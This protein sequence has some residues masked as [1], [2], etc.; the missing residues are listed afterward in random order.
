MPFDQVAASSLA[1]V[2]GK[3][4]NLG[5]L[6]AAGFPVPPGFVVTTQAYELGKSVV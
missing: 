2:G 4:L 1:A 5:V 3:A 6:T